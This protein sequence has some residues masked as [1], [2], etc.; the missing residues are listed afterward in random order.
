MRIKIKKWTLGMDNE[1][2]I[3]DKNDNPISGIGKVGGTKNRPL[4]IGKACG[5]QEDNVA[6]EVTMPPCTTAEELLYYVN[7]TKN[8]V[9]KHLNLKGAN[10]RLVAQS[11]AIFDESQLLD[12]AAKIFGCSGSFCVYTGGGSQRK[13]ASEA[14]NLRAFGAHVHVGWVTTQKKIYKTLN[15]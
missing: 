8:T 3:L 6:A 1:Y 15:V 4:D 9:E 11:S 2:L 13:S 10:L 5:R 12:R 14:G 7:Y